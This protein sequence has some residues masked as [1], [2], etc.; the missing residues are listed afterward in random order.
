MSSRTFGVE[1]AE[2]GTVRFT[3][4]TTHT[5]LCT[6]TAQR[7]LPAR[8]WL[9]PFL[10][11][12]VT[13][14]ACTDARDAQAEL[15]PCTTAAPTMSDVVVFVSDIDKS[16][17]WYEDNVGLAKISESLIAERRLG[18]R[19]IVMTRDGVGLTLVVSARAAPR[20]SD[21]QVVCFLLDGPPAPS[22]GSKP[23]FLVDPDGTSVELPPF[24]ARSRGGV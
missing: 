3:G 1:A 8:C 15:G 14:A 22:P 16:A 7:W 24:R 4:S 6:W 13:L 20:H 19:A 23:F 18:T 2:I 11:A 12:I 17:L 5:L 10:V 21:P 9:R